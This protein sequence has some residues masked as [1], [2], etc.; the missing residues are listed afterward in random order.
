MKKTEEE[1]KSLNSEGKEVIE[2][3]SSQMSYDSRL[4][5]FDKF[6]KLLVSVPQYIPNE[7]ELKVASLTAK[8]NELKLRNR[9]AVSAAIMLSNARISRNEILYKEITG[10]VDITVDIKSYI[11][12]LFGATSPQFRQVSKLTFNSVK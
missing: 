6:I 9:D 8:C 3:S 10:M 5:N 12:S 1:K 11:K 2:I 4:D 7:E